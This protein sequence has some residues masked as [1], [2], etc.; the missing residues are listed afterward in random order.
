RRKSEHLRIVAEEDVLHSGGTLLDCVQLLHCALPELDL[1]DIDLSAQL[2]GKPLRLPLMITSMTGGAA[3]AG[4]LNRD[5]AATAQRLG[6]A[7][8]VGSQRVLWDQPQA[9]PDFAVRKLMPDAVLLGNIGGA[10]LIEQP[11]SR[12]VELIQM[13]D[14]DGLCVHLNP[15]QELVQPDG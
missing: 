5:L 4:E 1:N 14:A 2:F 13:I 6:I 12:L 10:Q 15:A 11:T 9:L 8:A 7:F 3:L